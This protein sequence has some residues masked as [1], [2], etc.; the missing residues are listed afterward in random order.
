MPQNGALGGDIMFDWKLLVSKMAEKESTF[1]L[2][3]NYEK[4]TPVREIIS[5]ENYCR[6]S[7]LV[8]VAVPAYCRACGVHNMLFKCN[9]CH[10]N[11]GSVIL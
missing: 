7:C 10:C 1:C 5:T 11:C 8:T 2:Y 9:K 6:V 4:T 3:M